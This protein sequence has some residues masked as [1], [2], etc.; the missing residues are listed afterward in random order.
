[1]DSLVEKFIRY[2]KCNTMSDPDSETVPSTKRQF[3]LAKMLRDELIKIGLKDVELTDKC[4]ITATIP[5]NIDKDVRKVGFIAHVDTSP[6]M[7][8]DHVNPRIINNYDGKDI[9]LN[10]EKN[11]VTSV[12]DFPEL[13]NYVGDD[14]IVTDGTTL[15]GSDDK[16]GVAEIVDA[17]EYLMTHPEIKHGEV[18]VGFTPDEEIG[19]GPKYFD[20]KKFN[21]DAAYTLDGGALGGIDYENFNAADCKFTIEGRSVHTGSAKNKMTNSMSVAHELISM[22]PADEVPEKT[23]GYEGFFH[24]CDMKG[25]VEETKLHFI[26][27]DFDK[28]GFKNR[29]E[30]VK[31]I[32]E[33]I[34][35]KYGRE[36]VKVS[37]YDQYYN[38]REKIEPNKFV[39]DIAI[40]A[41]KE[42]DIK[43]VVQPIRG[44]TDGA[45]ISYMG[46]PTPNL[47]VGGEN[48]HGKFEYA[49]VKSMHR[50]EDTILKII[51][52]FSRDE[53]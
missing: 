47:F 22:L 48:F 8:S 32:A 27:R 34:N 17:A 26:I 24:L 37:L 18:R 43:P 53:K 41:M 11:I 2:A 35:K 39:V 20:V 12:K 4:Y 9:V 42:L 30:L 13:K 6:D 10:K 28:D 21:C 49:S 1:M 33:K 38:M 45:T 51:E 36:L 14:L 19:R 44:G 31:E 16:S 29:K 25:C 23:D 5:S 15:L 46:L 3:V 7:A 50:A 40:Q 52:I